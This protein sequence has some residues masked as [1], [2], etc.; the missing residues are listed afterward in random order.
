MHWLGLVVGDDWAS[1]LAQLGPHLVG[2]AWARTEAVAPRHDSEAQQQAWT[3][4]RRTRWDA[5][6]IEH[7]LLRPASP[8]LTAKNRTRPVPHCSWEYEP[9]PTPTYWC[10]GYVANLE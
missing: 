7:D 5:W 6:R 9:N 1:A 8:L 3:R 4:L 10:Q 2:Q